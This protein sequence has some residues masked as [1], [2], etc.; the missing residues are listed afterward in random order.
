MHHITLR[1][2][3]I[4]S[5]LFGLNPTHRAVI[6]FMLL[7]LQDVLRSEYGITIERLSRAFGMVFFRAKMGT[8]YFDLIECHLTCHSLSFG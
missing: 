7:F 4:G 3:F 5:V 2:Q 8:L 1:T 6:M